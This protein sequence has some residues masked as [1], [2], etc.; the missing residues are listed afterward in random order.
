[1]S[2]M[3][4]AY[5][6]VS[7]DNSDQD[8]TMFNDAER[9][10]RMAIKEELDAYKIMQSS[11]LSQLLLLTETPDL[12]SVLKEL[13][14]NISYD[15]ERNAKANILE[16]TSVY[17]EL[18]NLIDE[19]E[20]LHYIGDL[21]RVRKRHRRLKRKLS[22]WLVP[23][24]LVIRAIIKVTE[25]SEYENV[26][27]E[28]SSLRKATN[29]QLNRYAH[30][31]N[32]LVSSN[33]RLVFS[34]A[35]RFRYLGLPYEDLVQEGSFGLIKAIERF[36][37]KKGYLFSTYA[38][39]PISQTI[40][41]AIEQH[42]STVRKPN[43]LMR[44]KA[45]VDQTRAR[46]EQSLSRPPRSSDFEQSLPCTIDKRSAHI[47]L[48]IQPTADIENY[49]MSSNSP[50]LHPSLERS[51]QDFKTQFL[52]YKDFLEAAL[53]KLD[54]RTRQIVRMRFGIG[55]NRTYTLKEIGETLSIST[56]RTRQISLEAVKTLKEIYQ[57]DN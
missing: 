15:A 9:L 35:K 54:Q 8:L 11:A 50:E 2:S 56:E 39:R 19:L 16:Q 12:L 26:F 46:L 52:S 51:K 14:E 44:D 7:S 29:E 27:N 31:R 42:A 25:S 28:K 34:I 5:K 37:P 1:M 10:P 24:H 4:S 48:N 53:S 55:I 49:H 33:L 22:E 32:R 18:L 41:F 13:I 36:N 23:R 43:N 21:M 20:V 47:A 17:L 45:V 3:N 30:Q 6:I 57:V 40:H 38:Y